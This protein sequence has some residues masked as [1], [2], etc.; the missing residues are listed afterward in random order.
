MEPTLGNAALEV[1]E[2]TD[3]INK[4]QISV[5]LRYVANGEV[6]CEVKRSF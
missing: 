2:T 3:V 1:D 4:A 5:I 6:A